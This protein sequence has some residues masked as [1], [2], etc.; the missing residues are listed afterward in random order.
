LPFTTLYSQGTVGGT[1]AW[2]TPVQV[3]GYKTTG[4]IMFAIHIV[5]DPPLLRPPAPRPSIAPRCDPRDLLQFAL[6][7]ERRMRKHEYCADRNLQVF[8][9]LCTIYH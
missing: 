8:I 4:P 7:W 1:F 3:I 9:K 6:S 2:N 5:L